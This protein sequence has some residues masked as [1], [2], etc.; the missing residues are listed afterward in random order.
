[1]FGKV[2][3]FIENVCWILTAN[4]H[5]KPSPS[6]PPNR[7]KLAARN[8]TLMDF[9]YHFWQGHK[10]HFEFVRGSTVVRS[11][12]GRHSTLKKGLPDPANYFSLDRPF[13]AKKL[14]QKKR[15][16]A[17]EQAWWFSHH[18]CPP[19]VLDLNIQGFWF[20]IEFT[21]RFQS[22]KGF[23]WNHSQIESNLIQII[24]THYV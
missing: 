15:E 12:C 3:Y 23:L 8:R 11:M 10:I 22:Y 1:M 2:S 5:A 7:S 16:R 14:Y 17:E 24:P 21:P 19:G 4:H 6:T 18:S 9:S 13:I 20:S